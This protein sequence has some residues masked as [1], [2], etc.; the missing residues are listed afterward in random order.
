MGT[1]KVMVGDEVERR[2]RRVAMGR[3]GYGRGAL[4]EAAEAALSEW[5]SGEDMEVDLPPGLEDPVS[6]IEGLLAN[7]R[8]T[9]VELQH[10]A[11][12]IRVKRARA[13]TLG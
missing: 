9:S 4:S 5:S 8:A 10:D 6:A 11:R 1:I 13:K 3:Y 7:T 2:F 12:R